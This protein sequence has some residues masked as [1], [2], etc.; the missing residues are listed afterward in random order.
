[1]NYDTVEELTL[2]L[3]LYPNRKKEI[4]KDAAMHCEYGWFAVA[5]DGNC[6]LFNNDYELDDINKVKRLTF[7]MIPQ[8]VHRINIP[9]SVTMID[10]Y[11][12]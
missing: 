1:M 3:A 11:A 9:S 8:D 5:N 7:T 4:L 6:A 12:F 10:E 2:E